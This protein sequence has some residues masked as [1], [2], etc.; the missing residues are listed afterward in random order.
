MFLLVY[1]GALCAWLRVPCHSRCDYIAD[2][3][4]WSQLRAHDL[5]RTNVFPRD[6]GHI[7]TH[8]SSHTNQ[9]ACLLVIIYDP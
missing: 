3:C 2:K 1:Y 6:D 7:P 4:A 9:I 5:N 8:V